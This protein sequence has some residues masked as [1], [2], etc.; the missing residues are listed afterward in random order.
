MRR[1]LFTILS[2]VLIPFLIIV[3]LFLWFRSYYCNPV[4]KDWYNYTAFPD[5]NSPYNEIYDGSYSIKIEGDNVIFKPL[6]GEEVKG[7]ITVTPEDEHYDSA[8]ITIEFENGITAHGYC[9][10]NNDGRRLSFEYT[11]ERYSFKGKRGTSQEEMLEYRA[12][13]IEFLYSVYETGYFP[14]LE[15]IEADSLYKEYTNFRQTD[16]GHGGPKHCAV[17]SKVTIEEV[18]FENCL[19]T[20]RN[21]DGET[22]QFR[23]DDETEVSYVSND[24]ISKMRVEDLTAGSCLITDDGIDYSSTDDIIYI[25]KN[26]NIYYFEKR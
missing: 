25:Y 6:N 23:F 26:L 20:V 8:D 7:K 16:P 13:L 17:L 9:V 18:D 4:G 5:I 10:R 22:K 19:I 24:Q 1:F 14:T 15:E 3:F 12:G 11:E 21:A 2:I